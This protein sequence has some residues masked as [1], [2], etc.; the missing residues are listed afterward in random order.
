[1]NGEFNL[2][3]VVVVQVTD[4]HT[5]RA[6]QSWRLPVNFAP[7]ITTTALPAAK[8]G[9]DYS[10][11]FQDPN[12][13]NR[14]T[15]TD[16][17]F[18]DYHTYQ[19]IYEGDVDTVYTDSHYQVGAT[20]LKGSTPR[21]LH[22]DPYSGVLTGT[23]GINDAPRTASTSC[24]GPDTVVV[25]VT[26]QCG[27]MAWTT[28]PLTVDSTQHRPSFQRGQHIL[29]VTNKTAFCDSSI[30]LSDLDLTRLG[31]LENLTVR[32]LGD[33]AGF[34]VTPSTIT[35]SLAHD[36]VG[37]KIC[38]QFNKDD[39][40]FNT[41]PP[42]PDTIKL[43]VTDVGGNM[44]TL[45]YVIHIGDIPTFECAIDVSNAITTSHPLQDIQHLCFGAGRFGTDSLDIRYCE[46]EVPPPPYQSVFDARWELPIGGQIEGSYVDV[47][48]DTNQYANITWQ[49]RFNAG[50]ESGA[51]MYPMEICWS[52]SCLDPTSSKLAGTTFATG[53]FYLRQAQNANEFSI[54]MFTGKG[55]ID[56]SLYT[57]MPVGSDTLCLQIRDI[58]LKNAL[59]VFQPAKSDVGPTASTPQFSIEPNYPNPF[60]SSTTLNFAVAERSNVRVDV[61]DVKGTLVRT[62]V[63]EELDPGTYPVTWDATDANGHEM[64]NGSYIARMTAGSFTSSVKMSLTK[65]SK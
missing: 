62:L 11:N 12:L 58:N 61:Y 1:M 9:I 63:N 48:R 54:D 26:D 17:N 10:L 31:C 4:G 47:R 7:V 28:F 27:L 18:A 41:N 33:T 5:G 45:T 20:V 51:S 22:I 50:S 32:K 25:V 19:L 64:A 6:V 42:I 30:S 16:P 37:I 39:S 24:G 2:D 65:M 52:K 8:E 53:H 56:N 55:L 35:G 59:I 44:D 13:V 15:I 34:T 46:F 3:T 21:W 60:T 38:G 43:L 40:Y 36:T 57:L 49:V 23:P 29:C 14:I